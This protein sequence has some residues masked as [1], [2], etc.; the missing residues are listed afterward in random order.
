MMSRCSICFT[1][2]FNVDFGCCPFFVLTGHRRPPQEL[3]Q[4]Q[5]IHTST[6]WRTVPEHRMSGVRVAGKSF[7]CG[8]VAA[9][10]SGHMFPEVPFP[11]RLGAGDERV[12]ASR[13]AFATA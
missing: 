10:L 9:F 6:I 3:V 13:C 4:E 11:D 2:T 5:N 12:A 8:Y 1:E 7:V